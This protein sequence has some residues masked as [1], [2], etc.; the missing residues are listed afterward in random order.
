MSELMNMDVREIKGVGSKTQIDLKKLGILTVKDLI[1]FYPKSYENWLNPIEIDELYGLNTYGCI[2]I[3]I[4]SGVRKIFLNDGR[5]IYKVK[6][7]DGKN[8]VDIVIFN[9]RYVAMNLHFNKE[10]FLMGNITK[11]FSGYQ[12]ISPKISNKNLGLNPIYSQTKGISSKK[13]QTLI[14]NTFEMFTDQIKDTLPYEVRVKYNLC[15]LDFALRK[16]H[17]PNNMDDVKIARERL[18]FEEIF[19]WQISMA[20]VKKYVRKRTDIKILK[21]YT[22]EFL[23]LLP[24]IPTKAQIRA[25]KEC[26]NDMSQENTLA[27]SRLIQ[28]DVGSGKTVVAAALAYNIVKNGFQVAVMVPTELLCVQHYNTFNKIL[29]GMDI[30][31]DILSGNLKKSEKN[32]IL[33]KIKNGESHIVIGTH[34]LISQNVEFMNL[35]LVIA[36]EQHRFGVMQRTMLA[37]KGSNP[38]MLIMSATPIPR[39]LSLIVY[40]DLDVSILDELPPGRKG[41]KTFCIN[42]SKRTRALGFVKN[43]LNEGG[44]AYIVCPGIEDK[45]NTMSVKGYKKSIPDEILNNYK[46]EIIHGK[47]STAERDDIMKRFSCGETDLLI[48]TTVIE[49]GVDVPN[50]CIIMIENAEKFGLSQLHQLRGRVGR[51]E[52]ESYCILISDICSYDSKMRFKAMC[53]TNDGFC[54]ADED[55]KIRGPGEVFGNKQHG[56]VG[57]GLAKNFQDMNILKK[58]Q[59][60]VKDVILN[61]F[62]MEGEEWSLLKGKINEIIK[63]TKNDIIM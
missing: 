30:N 55:L 51:G 22:D 42:S 44:Q 19:L 18:I 50:A 39:T 63:S 48:S 27:M 56:M 16:I 12:I 13:I 26:I 14:R 40:G 3:K 57:V 49:V 2:K 11:T 41:V 34:A 7:S 45:E 46:T 28:G 20:I 17:F 24:F 54:L 32:K 35:G 62:N 1:S 52:K 47:M 4:I 37:K 10:F 29:D 23:F 9:S 36:D 15:T 60:A 53:S 38:H 33:N 21:D 43:I 59:E 25:I 8:E 31:I 6:G 58:S 61:G 5:Q